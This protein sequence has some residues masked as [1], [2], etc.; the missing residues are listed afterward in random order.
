MMP[1][2]FLPGPDPDFPYLDETERYQFPAPEKAPG[3]I[4]AIGGNLS[5][6]MLLSAYEQ[7]IFPWYGEGDPLLWQSP[8]PRFVLFPHKLHIAKS[9]Q[10]VLNKKVFDIAFNRDFTAVITNCA[11]IARHG[12]AG[13]WI[14]KDMIAA[15]SELFRLGYAECAESYSDGVLVGGCY[16]I[17][18]GNVFYGESMFAK[19]TNASKAAFLVFAQKL[20]AEGIRFIDC[21]VPTVHLKS[22]GAV[23]ISRKEFLRLL[24]V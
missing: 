17:K 19:E 3:D 1:K 18:L 20:F 8:D 13:T 2:A 14:T 6:G 7:G 9:M 12:Q 23:T 22:L 16:G 24:D 10:K 4:V 21:Q 5:P 15:Y 11:Q